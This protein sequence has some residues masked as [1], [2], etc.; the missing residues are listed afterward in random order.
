VLFK[1]ENDLADVNKSRQETIGSLTSQ[2]SEQTSLG[3]M[4]LL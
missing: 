4:M 2:L 1:Q 3:E